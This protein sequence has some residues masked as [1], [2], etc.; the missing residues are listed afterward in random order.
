MAR[1]KR[2]FQGMSYREVQRS[3][4]E[5]RKKLDRPQQVIL[6]EQGH[7]NLGW[8]SVISLYLAIEAFQQPPEP[9]DDTTLEELFLEA[10]RIGDKYQTHEDRSAFREALDREIA[11]I[12]DL[13][14]QHFPQTPEITKIDYSKT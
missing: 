4:S 12:N 3:N 6:K 14:E 9:E 11:E 7:R 2:D 1:K 10:A 5:N 13:I 8:D